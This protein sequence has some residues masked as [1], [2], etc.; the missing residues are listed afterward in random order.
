MN[1]CCTDS[2]CRSRGVFRWYDGDVPIRRSI[3]FGARKRLDCFHRGQRDLTQKITAP[4][5]GMSTPFKPYIQSSCELMDPLQVDYLFGLYDEAGKPVL[6]VQK[7]PKFVFLIGAP[8]AGK[9]SGH[10]MLQE[11]GIV[12]RTPSGIKDYATINVDSLL[13]A[14]IPFRE[15]TATAEKMGVELTAL[16]GYVSKQPNLGFVTGLQKELFPENVEE[17]G[18]KKKA[19]VSAAPTNTNLQKK[20]ELEAKKATCAPILKDIIRSYDDIL[21]GGPMPNNLNQIMEEALKRIIGASVDIV[22][23]TTFSSPD[24]FWKIYEMLKASPYKN[25]I[26]VM[27]IQGEP[28]VVAEKAELR[29]RYG[30]PS[31][32]LPFQRLVPTSV[33]HVADLI[34]K[35]QTV[36]NQ[37]VKEAPEGVQFIEI[38]PIP[39][40]ISLA[41]APP[42]ANTRSLAEQLTELRAKYP[43]RGGRRT[44]RHAIRKSKTSTKKSLRRRRD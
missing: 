26:V 24:K 35:N 33:V 34:Q 42:P 37:L 1:T 18:P 28:S 10:K 27:H 11:R 7:A 6:T 31:E 22:Y 4:F 39:F 8:A 2:I 9:S 44:R 19:K 5:R 23:E 3:G 14:L 41:P 30:M 21:K 16:R 15:A 25:N 17:T 32:P 20:A 38:P 12:S 13:E 40:S 29:Q 36:Y 43:R